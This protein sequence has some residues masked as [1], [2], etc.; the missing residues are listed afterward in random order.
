MRT[1][2]WTLRAAEG[3]CPRGLL[4]GRADAIGIR[5]GFGRPH[6]A[7][8]DAFLRGLSESRSNF[9]GSPTSGVSV[10]LV[11][12]WVE[13]RLERLRALLPFAVFAMIGSL[14]FA[15]MCDA[16]GDHNGITTVDG[17]VSLWFAAHR[18]ITDGHLGLLLAKATSPAVLIGIVAVTALVLRRK[19]FRQESTLLAGA[20]VIAY[21]CGAA[22]KYAEHRAR[23]VSPVNLAPESEPSFPSGHVLV[24]ATVAVV[25][26]GLAWVYLN[27]SSRVLA[28][29]AATT[30]TMLVALDRLVVGAH[31]FTD[32]VGSL[33]LAGVIAA[34]VLAAHAM[35]RP[36]R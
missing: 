15:W 22:A 17:P 27:R 36:S 9:G 12:D 4:R 1:M 21:A 5:R 33:A 3:A 20:T 23:P 6:P 8:F 11:L 16:V 13:P 24:V 26:V 34:A 29:V 35:L 25:V 18:S 32:V 19:G 10:L 2:G 30:T 7:R 31:W 28:V 14:V